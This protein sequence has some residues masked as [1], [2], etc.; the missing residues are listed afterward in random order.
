M[1]YKTILMGLLEQ[2][3]EIQNE[4]RAKRLLLTTLNSYAKEL[5]NSHRA[6][7]QCLSRIWPDKS[8]S[9]IASE[10]LDIALREM[11]HSLLTKTQP[12]DCSQLSLKDAMAF[13]R[14]H[15][16]VG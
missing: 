8:E 14:G 15:G 7:K 9:Q 6:W 2:Y 13:I 16:P 1:H 12:E 11:E 4:L 10:A 5:R 3:P